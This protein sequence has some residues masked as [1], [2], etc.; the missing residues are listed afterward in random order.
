MKRLASLA[1][2][3]SAFLGGSG[4]GVAAEESGTTA[5]QQ[6]SIESRRFDGISEKDLL[7]ASVN[8]FQDMGFNIDDADSSLGTVTASKTWVPEDP[9]GVREMKGVS[10]MLISTS[11]LEIYR[12]YVS[13]FQEDYRA[14]LVVKPALAEQSAPIKP[15]DAKKSKKTGANA[16][17]QKPAEPTSFIVRVV[18]QKATRVKAYG[19]PSAQGLSSAQQQFNGEAIKDPAIYQ[20]FFENLSKSVFLEAQQL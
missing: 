12:R 8:V 9:I 4:L 1:L 3:F 18:F 14:S 16:D 6:R 17:T 15:D 13:D 5:L 2:L 10:A 20:E 19:P 11:L 7:S